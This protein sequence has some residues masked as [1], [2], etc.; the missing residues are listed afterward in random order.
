LVAQMIGSATKVFMHEYLDCVAR[1][2]FFQ[3]S[4]LWS[5]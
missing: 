3:W 2:V 1:P 4:V 5:C